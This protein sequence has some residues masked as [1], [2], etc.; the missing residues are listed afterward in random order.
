MA[1]VTLKIGAADP[2]ELS[3][4]SFAEVVLR[5]VVGGVS[6]LTL[7]RVQ[8]LAAAAAMA[9]GDAV[10]L[11][12]DG[13]VKFAGV[14]REVTHDLGP[15][16]MVIYQCLDAWYDLD[17]L[18]WQDERNLA[19]DP[20]DP[21]SPMSAVKTSRTVLFQAL[22]GSAVLPADQIDAAL[23]FAVLAGVSVT[24]GSLHAMGAVPWE[25]ATDITVAEV[26]RRAARWLPFG[27]LHLRY[28][29][30]LATLDLKAKADLP[31]TTID[32][33]AGALRRLAIR[34]RSDLV[35]PGVKLFFEGVQVIEGDGETETRAKI[36][37]QTAGATSGPG[38]VIAYIEL[39]SQGSD[40][41]ETPPAGVALAYWS[42]LNDAVHGGSITLKGQECDWTLDLGQRLQFS[43]GLE[44]WESM[45]A[46]VQAVTHDVMGGETTVEF[47]PSEAMSISVFADLIAFR[48][49]RSRTNFPETRRD[50]RGATTALPSSSTG[51]GE[52]GG[53]IPQFVEIEVC[54]PTA[55]TIRAVGTFTAA[56]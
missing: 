24:T 22:D 46:P 32:L 7:R 49:M 2:V 29:A 38:A 9:E 14:C 50:G 33:T 21:E 34:K 5:R 52:G 36:T 51:G 8:A 12:V 48:R 4:L 37:T 13:A 6:A 30:G 10:R 15:G 25:E 11:L 42:Q 3:T 1:T 53:I 54:H 44:E 17:R 47:G 40:V 20:E 41:P 55:G 28:P 35:V 16:A 56:E 23:D 31:V 43:N 26:L 18:I 19:D 27:A 45:M 39:A